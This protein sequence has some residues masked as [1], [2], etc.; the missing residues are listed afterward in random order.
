MIDTVW[1]DTLYLLLYLLPYEV[2]FPVKSHTQRVNM[3]PFIAR[4]S[5]TSSESESESD[6]AL[7]VVCDFSD[8]I[9]NKSH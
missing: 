8:A 1:S 7:K 9:A 2:R 5:F 6:A 4:G 3:I